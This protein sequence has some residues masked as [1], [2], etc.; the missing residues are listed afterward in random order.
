MFDKGLNEIHQSGS[1][2]RCSDYYGRH[3][4]NDAQILVGI[5]IGKY[6]HLLRRSD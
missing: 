2:M 5:L 4:E 3:P 1:R 6:L